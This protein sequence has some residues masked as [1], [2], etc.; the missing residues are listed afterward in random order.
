[1]SEAVKLSFTARVTNEKGESFS[2]KVGGRNGWFLLV[3]MDRGKRGLSTIERQGPRMS[4]YAM[5]LRRKGINIATHWESHGGSFGGEHGRYE[6][7][8]TV[9]VEGG[10]LSQ[11]LNSPEGRREFPRQTFG[12]AA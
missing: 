10:T 6:L 9:K 8:D 5:L 12:V 11:W 1:M 2:V 7:L 3:L 4:Q